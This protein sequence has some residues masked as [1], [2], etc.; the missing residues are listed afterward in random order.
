[1]MSPDAPLRLEIQGLTKRY[2]GVVANDGVSLKVKAGEIHA[3]IGENG[4]GKSTLVKCVYGLVR[5]DAGRIVWDGMQVTI[6]S[7]V[8]ARRLGIGMVFQHFSLFEALTVIENIAL[9]LD[10]AKDDAALRAR[11]A[12]ILATYSLPLDPD[13]PVH[14]LSVGERQRIE[15]V[16]C[17]L[18][19]P[20]LL[21]MDEPT[22]VLTPQEADRLFATLR[23]I[24]AEGC[25]ILYISHKL[26]EVRALCEAATILRGGKVVGHCDPRAETPRRMAELMVGASFGDARRDAGAVTGKL[27]LALDGLTLAPDEPHGVPLRAISLEVHAGEILGIAGV[28]GNGQKELMLALSGERLSAAEQIRLDTM[29]IGQVAPGAR[30]RAG[31]CVAPEERNGHAAIPEFSLAENALLTARHRKPLAP[32]GLVAQGATDSFANEVIAAFDVRTTGPAAL[33]RSLSGGN[34]QKFVIGREVAQAPAALAVAQPTWGVDAGAAETIRQALIHLAE[35]GAAVI[36]VSQDLDELFA[37]S[38]RIA[39]LNEGRLS[40]AIPVADATPERLGLMMGGV[41]AEV[42]A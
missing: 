16:R 38:D 2:P 40:A 24:A 1:M 20:R 19:N 6:G 21:I 9:G 18:Q 29:P 5:P 15:I 12:D 41:A 3:L 35:A 11:V 33:A 7:P 4:A 31:L 10:G 42:A 13:R 39:V 14:T 32:G 23:R 25:A 36:V 27:R 28:A 37:L 26:G 34:L 30:R 17:L 22:S 8:A